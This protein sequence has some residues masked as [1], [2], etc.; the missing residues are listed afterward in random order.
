[1]GPESC[2]QCIE[3]PEVARRCSFCGWVDEDGQ[4][5]QAGV[6]HRLNG[7]GERIIIN[8]RKKELDGSELVIGKIVRV[9]THE[10][11]YHVV[12]PPLTV[13]RM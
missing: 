13:N 6:C 2:R 8:Q 10:F 3:T 11:S 1:M 9:N 5:G 12:L 7:F 4:L